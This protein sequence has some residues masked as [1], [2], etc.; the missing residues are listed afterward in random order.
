MP[1]SFYASLDSFVCHI[2]ALTPW[3]HASSRSLRDALYISEA[4][5]HQDGPLNRKC[6]QSGRAPVHQKLRWRRS[7]HQLQK[8]LTILACTIARK[9]P[10]LGWGR[11]K[12]DKGRHCLMNYVMDSIFIQV[13]SLLARCNKGWLTH[14]R[15]GR[16]L[17]QRK[18][19]PCLNAGE[20]LQLN[21]Y[22][23]NDFDVEKT[24]LH[25]KRQDLINT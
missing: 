1:D 5:Y 8:E 14:W 19:W 2:P 13:I 24:W 10:Q 6:S 23:H 12:E 18:D 9:T 11:C 15:A 4:A 21:V 16:V 3:Q 7:Q 17:E 25:N 22:I 20:Y